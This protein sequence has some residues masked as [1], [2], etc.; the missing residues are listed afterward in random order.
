MSHFQSS[1]WWE[2]GN[3]H[4]KTIAEWLAA[5]DQNRMATT[6]DILFA[7]RED[8]GAQVD[9]SNAEALMAAVLQ[10]MFCITGATQD[11][12]ETYTLK[13]ADVALVSAQALG[14]LPAAGE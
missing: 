12:P 13:V 10:L 8:L 1:R 6:L 7:L 2:G 11:Y 4:D 5:N 3:L 14:Y 9:L